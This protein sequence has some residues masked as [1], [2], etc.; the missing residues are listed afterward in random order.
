MKSFHKK[1]MSLAFGSGIPAIVLFILFYMIPGMGHAQWNTDT[2]V[3]LP[4]SS[5]EVADMETASTTDGKTWIAFYVQN[6]G[7]YDM[8]AQLL[9]AN[10]YKLLGTDGMLVSNHTSG[11]ATF[12]FNVCVDASNNLIIAFQD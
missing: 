1:L 7:N 2:Y 12:V 4:I 11:S 6:S 3:N 8:Y 10:G 9:D 5:F